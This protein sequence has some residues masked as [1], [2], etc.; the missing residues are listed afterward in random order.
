MKV[1]V[2]SQENAAP[3]PPKNTQRVVG[4]PRMNKIESQHHRKR[5]YNFGRCGS[6]GHNKKM[7]QRTT[8]VID[9]H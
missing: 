2:D 5:K 3:K 1:F 6:S 7:I 8:C 4:P 9:A